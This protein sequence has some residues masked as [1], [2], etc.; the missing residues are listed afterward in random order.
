M[1]F[2]LAFIV[3]AQHLGE[4]T[5]SVHEVFSSTFEGRRLARVHLRLHS[6][7]SSTPFEWACS[8]R[9]ALVYLA[10]AEAGHLLWPRVRTS[11]ALD[12]RRQSLLPG[13]APSAPRRPP[14]LRVLTPGFDAFLSFAGDFP[15]F[16]WVV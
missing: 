14:S 16:P 7:W 3:D 13:D 5:D 10:F 15:W 11:A 12:T 9:I 2:T 4:F 8:S 1:I 6:V